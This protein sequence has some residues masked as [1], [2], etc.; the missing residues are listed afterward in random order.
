MFIWESCFDI[1]II[2]RSI[3]MHGTLCGQRLSSLLNIVQNCFTCTIFQI[4]AKLSEKTWEY[5]ITKVIVNVQTSFW[6]L[7]IRKTYLLLTKYKSSWSF[8]FIF[9]L[10]RKLNR[11]TVLFFR[12]NFALRTLFKV[13]FGRFLITMYFMN[14][15]NSIQSE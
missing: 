11:R 10:L 5:K 15:K 14:K 6:I 8:L 7:P 3:N 1:S 13:F 2:N 9:T 4:W 12:I